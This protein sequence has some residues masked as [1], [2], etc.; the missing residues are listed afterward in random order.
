[1]LLAGGAV[2]PGFH[3]RFPGLNPA[4]LHRGDIPYTTD[5]RNV[6]ATILK[7]WMG[8]DETKVLGKRFEPL[9]LFKAV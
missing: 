5:F 9:D 4:T 2:R 3:G 1:M 7:R 6:Y 8:T